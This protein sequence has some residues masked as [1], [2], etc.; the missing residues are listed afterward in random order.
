MVQLQGFTDLRH[1]TGIQHHN[2]VCQG[3]RFDLIVGDVNHRAAKTF[4]QAGDFNTHLDAQRGV[5]VRQR[6]VQQEYS[7]L[8][9]QRTANR[10]TLT[11]STGKRFRFTV[12][13]VRQLQNFSYLINALVHYLFFRAGQFEAERHVFRDG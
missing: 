11:L 8:G 10:H 7:R 5:K 9:N 12:Q 6:F 13:Q 4:M 3:H 2:F 1:T